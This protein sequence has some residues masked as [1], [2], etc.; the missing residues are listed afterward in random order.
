MKRH[1]ALLPVI[2]L[3]LGACSS[4]EA[5]DNEENGDKKEITIAA[6]EGW[7]DTVASS[8]LWKA[9]L[10]EKGYDAEVEYVN[11]TTAFA[12]VAEGEYDLYLGSWLPTTHADYYENYGDQMENLGAWNDEAVN[13]V[14]VAADSPID[15]IPELLEHADEFDNRI[16][17]IEPGAGLT[18]MMEEEVIPTYGLESM[19]F[20]TSSSAA[21]LAELDTALANDENIAVTLW[22]PHWAYGTYDLKNLEDPEGALG[23]PEEITALASQDLRE[24]APQLVG[25]I[26]NFEMDMDMFGELQ[27]AMFAEDATDYEPGLNEWIDENRD[28][29]DG[30]TE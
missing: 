17:G 10:N 15:T 18:L 26:E 20:V 21:M 11:V 5:A 1:Y 13:T 2:A 28:W 27:A 29:V 4:G 30:L 7:D 6:V 25:W 12:G 24:E 16:V 22:Q 23:E 8:E 19:E 9:V 14:A 3:A